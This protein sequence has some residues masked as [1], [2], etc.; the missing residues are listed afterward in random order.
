MSFAAASFFLLYLFQ[1]KPPL[2]YFIVGRLFPFGTR[3]LRSAFARFWGMSDTQ[4][5][6]TD[7][8]HEDIAHHRMHDN[9]VKHLKAFM[10]HPFRLDSA[11]N[12][13]LLLQNEPSLYESV[14]LRYDISHVLYP[15]SS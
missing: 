3:K 5:K 15:I 1:K 6:K 11:A 13:M 7:I 8:T 12:A 2:K 10:E 4:V 14:V 9:L